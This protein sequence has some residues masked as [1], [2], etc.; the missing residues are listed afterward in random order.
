M[1]L[2][3]RQSRRPRVALLIRRRQS[4]GFICKLNP[5]LTHQAYSLVAAKRRNGKIE[6]QAQL[7]PDEPFNGLTASF[8]ANK[9]DAMACRGRA[10]GNYLCNVVHG[11]DLEARPLTP[12][13]KQRRTNR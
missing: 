10:R 1:R 11:E 2:Q 5:N 8:T 7:A 6:Q 3:E 4:K 12:A 9:S 13:C